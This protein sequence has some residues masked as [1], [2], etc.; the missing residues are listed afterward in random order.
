MAN[1][2]TANTGIPFSKAIPIHT[3]GLYKIQSDIANIIVFGSTTG[4]KVNYDGIKA[5]VELAISSIPD[6][7]QSSAL[8]EMMEKKEQ[9]AKQE[10]ANKN[11]HSTPTADD[12]Q[13]A[14][15]ESA[16]AIFNLVHV[17]YDDDMAIRKRMTIGVA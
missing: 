16:F 8:R 14:M 4:E 7:E 15:R 2:E 17:V 1:S 3:E 9:E 13:Q 10:I 11:H 5:L 12:E 6:S